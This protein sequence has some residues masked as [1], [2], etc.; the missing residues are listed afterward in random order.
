MTSATAEPRVTPSEEAKNQRPRKFGPDSPLSGTAAKYT[1]PLEHRWLDIARGSTNTTNRFNR[2][3]PAVGN[4]FAQ[5]LHIT[6]MA[7]QSSKARKRN[8]KPSLAKQIGH[9]SLATHFRVLRGRQIPC[10]SATLSQRGSRWSLTLDN[11]SYLG[12]VAK[13]M[14]F[15]ELRLDNDTVLSEIGAAPRPSEARWRALGLSDAE[16]HFMYLMDLSFRE[17]PLVALR[18]STTTPTATKRPRKST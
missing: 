10:V 14:Q 13:A 17:E 18:L 7:E 8:P 11:P 12:K 15:R 16:V 5:N 4:R 3:I 6:S 1:P 2:R 9:V